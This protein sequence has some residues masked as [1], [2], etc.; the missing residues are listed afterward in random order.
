[1]SLRYCPPESAPRS[2]GRLLIICALCLAGGLFAGCTGPSRLPVD[3]STGSLDASATPNRRAVSRDSLFQSCSGVALGKGVFELQCR[4]LHRF[5]VA[6]YDGS[7]SSNRCRAIIHRV[8]R[9]GTLR[10]GPRLGLPDSV[11][12]YR[13]RD[14]KRRDV[15]GEVGSTG[16]AACVPHRDGGLGL[17]L[18]QD[19]L[20]A[21]SLFTA[22]VLTTLA[23][24]GVPERR[25][26]SRSPK[27]VPFLGRALPVHSS[28][29]LKGAQNLSCFPNGQMNWGTFSTLDRA[30]EAQ[31][32]QRKA[33]RQS[34]AEVLADTTVGCMF[35]EVE[36]QCRRLVYRAP[37]SKLATLGASNVLI[38]FYAAARVRG[39]PSQAVCSFYRDQARSNGLAPLC[40][41]A[42][43]VPAADTLMR[44]TPK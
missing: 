36:T 1:M 42:F 26:L 23:Y 34:G 28:C 22:E 2:T 20:G 32:L 41:E 39:K 18:L 16:V 40:Q 6:R 37:V 13:L 21:D 25:V 19:G 7:P 29:E 30:Q 35:E 33:S 24:E 11:S 4:D 15:A 9:G 3:P 38:V 17:L 14:L 5:Y 31:R 43:E 44:R 12:T 8:Y 27:E 10:D